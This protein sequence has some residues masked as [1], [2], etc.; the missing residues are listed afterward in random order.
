VIARTLRQAALLIALAFVPAI[1]QA[2]YYRGKVSWQSRL[3]SAETVDVDLARSWG[4][5]AMWVDARP[6]NEFEAGHV[7]GAASLNE[8]RWNELLPPFLAQWSPDKKIVV[9]CSTKSCNLAEDVA[10]RLRNEVKLPNE[11][12]VL[13]GGW[14]E[15]QNKTRP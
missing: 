11:I 12:R 13:S 7:P 10:H 15:W 9:Y 8:D 4:E 1:G 14:E 3:T 2:I 6:D 5:N